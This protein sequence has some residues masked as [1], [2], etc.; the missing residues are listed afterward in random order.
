MKTGSMIRIGSLVH[1]ICARKATNF[2]SLCGAGSVSALRPS[3]AGRDSRGKGLTS[4]PLLE[5]RRFARQAVHL[6]GFLKN[7]DIGD[8]RHSRTGMSVPPHPVRSLEPLVNR[9]RGHKSELPPSHD[10]ILSTP[11]KSLPQQMRARAEFS[12]QVRWGNQDRK[13]LRPSL[14]TALFFQELQYRTIAERSAHLTR[15]EQS[16]ECMFH[17]REHGNFSLNVRDLRLG[18]FANILAGCR[19]VP[20]E[21]QKLLDFP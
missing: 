10:Y 2:T 20:H 14:Y 9:R 17:F 5:R 12:L 1:V 15:C 21:L 19:R 3:G 7:Q 8:S 11:E 4:R 6:A 18:F 16:A 13:R